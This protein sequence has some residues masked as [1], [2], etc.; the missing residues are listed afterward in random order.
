M[1]SIEA[2]TPRASLFSWFDPR[3]R[4]ATT[5]GFILNRITG[6]GLTLYLTLHL[7]MLGQLAQ[8][9]AAYDNFLKLVSSPIYVLGEVLVVAAG[10]IHGLNGIRIAFTS[11]GIAV[12]YQKQLLY[13]L[14]TLAILGSLYFAIQMFAA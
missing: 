3:F 5:W 14:M 13:V 4:S 1:E 12:P 10:L 9:A 7:I 6:L 2:K 8:G 11:F